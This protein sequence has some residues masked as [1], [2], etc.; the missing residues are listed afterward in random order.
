M[1]EPQNSSRN[2][3]EIVTKEY[4]TQQLSERKSTE[5]SE[6]YHSYQYQEQEGAEEKTNKVEQSD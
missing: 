2:D 6:S 1:P 4:Q 3:E 5:K